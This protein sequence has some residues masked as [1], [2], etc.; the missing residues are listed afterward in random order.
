MSTNPVP[1]VIEPGDFDF[2]AFKPPILEGLT[3]EDHRR[4]SPAEKWRRIGIAW[5]QVKEGHRRWYLD[6]FPDA[7]DV[8]IWG[9]WL[10]VTDCS[11]ILAKAMRDA[12]EREADEPLIVP[13]APDSSDGWKLSFHVREEYRRL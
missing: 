1:R 10:R 2:H 4:M 11:P 6:Q 5:G 7:S 12:A 9:D 8:E 3:I 13:V